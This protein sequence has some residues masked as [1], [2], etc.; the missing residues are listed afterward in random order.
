MSERIGENNLPL[1]PEKIEDEESEEIKYNLLWEE[2][3]DYGKG[4]VTNE[5][6]NPLKFKLEK[7]LTTLQPR[8]QEVLQLRF[9]LDGNGTHSLSKT[10]ELMGGTSKERIRQIQNR[11][12]EKL[13][14]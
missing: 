11:A 10:G 4:S 14:I 6:L 13:R 3:L 2:L 12:L 1:E 7:A 9:N 8:E 5:Q